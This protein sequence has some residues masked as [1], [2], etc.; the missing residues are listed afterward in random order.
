MKRVKILFQCVFIFS[1]AYYDPFTGGSRYVP[2]AGSDRDLPSGVNLDPFTGGAS[3]SSNKTA[4]TGSRFF[5]T[6][7]Y[8]TF[9]AKD[10]IKITQKLR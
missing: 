3:Y 7:E 10:L 1:Q 8:R 9:E 2:G 4:S 5:P 6:K